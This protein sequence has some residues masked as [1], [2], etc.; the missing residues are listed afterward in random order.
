LYTQSTLKKPHQLWDRPSIAL[1]LVCVWLPAALLQSTGWA[2]DLDQ[3]EFLALLGVTLGLIIGRTS[4]QSAICHLMFLIFTLIVPFWLFTVRMTPD[5]EWLFRFTVLLQRA[6]LALAQAVTG[7]VVQDSLIF[8]MFCSYFF[9]I[10]G[11]I[12]G[13]GF[14]RR[15][16]PWQG[17]LSAA[18]IFGVIDFYAGSSTIAL[19]GGA[20]LVLCLLLLSSRLFW[21]SQKKVWD[22]EGV[23]VER[24][25][26]DSIMRLA[27]ILGVILV[28]FAW[29]MQTI[30][31][32]FTPGTEENI[33]IS[34]FWRNVQSGLQNNFA[35]LQNS[36]SLTGSYSGGMQLGNQAPIKQNPVFQAKILA[37][38]QA[39]GPYLWR[40]RIYEEYVDGH[41]QSAKVQSFNSR[42][43]DLAAEGNLAPYSEVTAQYIWQEGD[44]SI[45]P[46][47]GR[48]QGLDIPHHLES[49]D[50]TGLVSGDGI[51]YPQ[52]PLKKDSLFILK[53]A[54]FTGK[55]QD[56][57]AAPYLVPPQISAENLKVP[58]SVPRRVRDLAANIAVGDNTLLRVQ[59]VNNYLRK[60]YEYKS[61]ISPIPSGRDPV[62]WFLF[63][64][65]QG[66]CNYFASAEVLFLRSAGIPARL[67]VGYSQGEKTEFGYLVRMKD[68]HAWP[69]VY[70]PNAGWVP[71]EP[72]PMQ[73]DRPYSTSNDDNREDV[74]NE[75]TA[76]DRR[77]NASL[78]PPTAGPSEADDAQ[79][80]TQTRWII[81]LILL[82]VVVLCAVGLWLVF[83]KKRWKKP[84]RLL[85]M[86]LDWM[87]A[88]HIPIPRWMAGWNWYSG[89]TVPA[90][91][92]FWIEKLALWTG[93]ISYLP[94]TPA[95]LLTGVAAKIPD[96][97]T[98][99]GQFQTGLYHELY[100]PDRK[101]A[102]LE[103]QKAG[104]IL[105]KGIL[106]EFW[107]KLTNSHSSR[108]R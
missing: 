50:I 100:S 53:S 103:C 15:W 21:V 31:R 43:L 52:S 18:G 72:T 93:L 76:E 7:R 8:T 105:Q 61:Q 40:I 32:S 106:K 23:Q 34:E 81:L 4:F 57:T 82:L 96:L 68:G 29:N 36:S 13:Y 44:G 71:F 62:D 45:I 30:I 20:V 24:D 22:A 1:I 25:A 12:T 48:F 104:N 9:W 58:D 85:Q 28:L 88:H 86:L 55:Q 99:A 6:N 90:R 78:P 108:G 49:S 11:Y 70:F 92:Y 84:P 54:V 79:K 47:S 17:L 2:P 74:R 26:S 14:S 69:E 83:V 64:S 89:L 97:R 16:N 67:A 77:A 27:S 95:E 102:F 37:G 39:A 98:A 91:Q 10:T 66:F 60:N 41:W 35:S 5:G 75:I 107:R 59:A 46:F 56:L 94:V 80:N 87:A 51:L 33:R 38:P 42:V 19:W 63:E 73:P 65:K 3:A 101:Y